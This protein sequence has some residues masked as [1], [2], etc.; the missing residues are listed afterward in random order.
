[1]VGKLVVQSFIPSYLIFLSR[2]PNAFAGSNVHSSLKPALTPVSRFL[3]ASK[4][5]LA[6]AQ[7]R[8]DATLKWRRDF[9]LSNGKLADSIIDPDV[10]FTD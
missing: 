3:R 7:K 5:S 10:R 9:G 6:T 8:L 4:G 2:L 1:M